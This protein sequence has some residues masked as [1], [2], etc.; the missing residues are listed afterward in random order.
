[1]TDRLSDALD[2]ALDDHVASGARRGTVSAEIDGARAEIDVTDADRLG[3]AVRG[4]KVSR[5]TSGEGAVGGGAPEPVVDVAAEA[6]RLSGGLRALPERV[7]A[8]EIDPRL[9]GAILRSDEGEMRGREFFEVD[10]RASGTT[11]VQRLRPAE[12]GGRNVVDH[13]MTR[14]QLGRLVDELVG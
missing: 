8:V 13:T 9:G 3:V 6:E 7:R 14:G 11:S 2:A 12:G 4:V 10:V 1:M 5:G